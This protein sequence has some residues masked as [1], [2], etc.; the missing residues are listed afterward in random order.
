MGKLIKKLGAFSLGPIMA[1]IIGCITVPII[2][3][4]ISPEEYGKA[5]M[6]TL[7]QGIASMLVYFGLDQAFVREFNR[8]RDNISELLSNAIFIPL[9]VTIIMGV[10]IIINSHFISKVLFGTENEVLAVYMLGIMLPF[11]A[12]ENF[13][14]LKIRMEEKGLI[15][16]CTTILLKLL[17]LAITVL[18]FITYEKSFRSV[19][20]AMALAEIINGCMLF[21]TVILPLKLRLKYV[22]STLIKSM[23]KFGIPLIPAMM[24][25]WILASMDKVMLR[26]LCGY[27]ELGL[28][29]AAYKIVSALSIIQSCFTLFW[30][31]VAYRWNEENVAKENYY[32]VNVVMSIGMTMLCLM[33]LIVKNIVGIVLGKSFVEAIYIFPFLLLYP[34][35][36]TMSE[37]TAIGIGFSRKTQYSIVVSGIA[38]LVNIILNYK[39]IPIW[40]GAGAAMATGIAFIVFF[41]VRTLISRKVWWN[42]SISIYIPISIVLI[43]NCYV[44]TFFSGKL[45]YIVSIASI[46]F[47]LIINIKSI[48][49]L[50]ENIRKR[51]ELEE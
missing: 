31:P 45:P 13:S 46:F 48:K 24:M 23:L 8:Y 26:A 49:V 50:I 15:Y 12:I 30:T 11:M 35:M 43:I 38:C 5:S 14:F 7:A 27:E 16:S 40:G 19:V 33:L 34:V 6:F 44:H 51:K 36:Y 41:W 17:V 29:T 28:Y 2:T 47:V 9:C 10:A 39:L 42:F 25:S 37:T 32:F 22:N 18:L 20:Y 3:Y 1:A 21:I 4:F